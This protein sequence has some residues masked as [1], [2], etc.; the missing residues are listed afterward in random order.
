MKV[1]RNKPGVGVI[2]PYSC[3][4]KM[5]LCVQQAQKHSWLLAMKLVV[6]SEL[7]QSLFILKHRW[8]FHMYIILFLITLSQWSSQAKR[9]YTHAL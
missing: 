2:V 4:C 5:H 7:S 6:C 3:H 9:P 8:Q 1:L